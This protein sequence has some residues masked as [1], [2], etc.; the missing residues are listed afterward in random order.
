[1][2]LYPTGSV[3]DVFRREG[4]HEY[5]FNEEA[6]VESYYRI[7][8]YPLL[9]DEVAASSTTSGSNTSNAARDGSNVNGDINTDIASV[10]DVLCN[11]VRTSIILSSKTSAMNIDEKKTSG[12]GFIFGIVTSGKL[13]ILSYISS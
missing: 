13:T 11:E 6:L 7:V 1:M 3:A 4:A 12:K 8:T 9:M 10:K 2:A 5:N